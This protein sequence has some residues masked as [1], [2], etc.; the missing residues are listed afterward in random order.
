MNEVRDGLLIVHATTLATWCGQARDIKLH[1][2]SVEVIPAA[3]PLDGPARPAYRS[4]CVMAFTACE[5]ALIPRPP[6]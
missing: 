1:T 5:A 3:P 6:S 4:A 2:S